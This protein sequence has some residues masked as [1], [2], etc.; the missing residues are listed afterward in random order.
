MTTYKYEI[1]ADTNFRNYTVYDEVTDLDP[2]GFIADEATGDSIC[3]DVL[4]AAG[5]VAS[6]QW[7][8]YGADGAMRLLYWATEEDADNDA[9]A[10]AMGQIV[11]TPVEA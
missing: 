7:D 1:P 10:N 8:T 6:P 9:G 3:E 11:K 5:L 4:A 2:D